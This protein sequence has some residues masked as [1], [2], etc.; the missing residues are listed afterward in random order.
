LPTPGWPPKG[1]STAQAAGATAKSVRS[2]TAMVPGQGG[3]A[4]V[5]PPSAPSASSTAAQGG[6]VV[7]APF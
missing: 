5:T 6:V 4:S 1:S 2:S 7:T 3:S